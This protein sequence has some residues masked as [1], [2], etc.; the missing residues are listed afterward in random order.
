M[1]SAP[2]LWLIAG[3][4]LCLMELIF[5]TAFVELMMGI[6]AILVAAVSLVVTHLT[7]QVFLWLFFSTT[8]IFLSQR[9]LAPKRKVSML[10]G[11]TE[12]ETL[13][14]IAPGQAGRVLYE[15]SSWRAVC[16]DENLAIAPHQKVYIVER[17]GNTL[18]VL[19]VT[20]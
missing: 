9:L 18:Y 4:I 11:D 6:S 3:S 19:P 20:F 17:K 16:A 10:E 12:G 13:T 7:L 5:P 1:L 2:L 14:E 8:S 15:G